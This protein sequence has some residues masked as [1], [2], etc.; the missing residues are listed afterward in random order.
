MAISKYNSFLSILAVVL[1][2]VSHTVTKSY[3]ALRF[4]S[5]SSSASAAALTCDLV[6]ASFGSNR[7]GLASISNCLR[8]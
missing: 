6:A 3:N 4:T 1:F 8:K 7:Y 5:S 2:V